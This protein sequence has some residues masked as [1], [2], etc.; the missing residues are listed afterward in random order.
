MNKFSADIHTS[1]PDLY[2]FLFLLAS[3]NLTCTG[4]SV[5][6]KLSKEKACDE[7]LNLLIY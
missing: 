7:L 5:K 4:L 1:K 6:S 2:I 3:A